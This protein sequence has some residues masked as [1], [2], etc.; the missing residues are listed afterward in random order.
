MS[1]QVNVSSIESFSGNNEV[2]KNWVFS[3]DA[4][5]VEQQDNGYQSFPNKFLRRTDDS[6]VIFAKRWEADLTRSTGLVTYGDKHLNYIDKTGQEYMITAEEGYDLIAVVGVDEEELENTEMPE[7]GNV[8][9]W[10]I[11]HD[12]TASEMA[13]NN[14]EAFR[15]LVAEKVVPWA[16]THM[17]DFQIY[18]V[19]AGL[20]SRLLR[21]S[22]D[23][24]QSW[25]SH[26]FHHYVAPIN[27]AFPETSWGR[28]AIRA[29]RSPLPKESFIYQATSSGSGLYSHLYQS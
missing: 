8:W 19:D 16:I 26:D 2:S 6:M 10:A 9:F 5:K 21:P 3:K 24:P 14:P 15:R 7:I 12:D 4:V 11:K 1:K 22:H 27:G 18:L 25:K 23:L 29:A 17:E 20:R 28:S 13:R